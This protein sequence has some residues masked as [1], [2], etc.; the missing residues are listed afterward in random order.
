MLL[1]IIMITESILPWLGL[2]IGGY[3]LGSVMFCRLICLIFFK[4]DITK[5]SKDKNPGAA[6]AFWYCGKVAGI[7]GL[8]LDMLKGFLPVFIAIKYLNPNSFAFVL[9][10]LAPVLGH[11]F[12]IFHNFSGG[13]CIATIYG[14]LIALFVTFIS[15]IFLV[16]LGILNILFEFVKKIPGNKRAYIMF[17]VL[18]FSALLVGFYYDKFII[19]AG[20]VAI[21][22]IAILKHSPLF[23]TEEKKRKRPRKASL[24]K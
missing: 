3:F 7:S 21:S 17:F 13:K 16:V 24:A 5:V 9:V 14:E 18:I 8:L 20:V 15:P 23:V 4:T 12:S 1:R 2:I 11:A 19:S 10:M 22:F 6:N